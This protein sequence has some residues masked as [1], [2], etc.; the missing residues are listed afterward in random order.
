MVCQ[1]GVPKVI[2]INWGI[3]KVLPIKPDGLVLGHPVDIKCCARLLLTVVS[4]YFVYVH[5]S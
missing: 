2:Q 4:V 3:L 1:C 5:V